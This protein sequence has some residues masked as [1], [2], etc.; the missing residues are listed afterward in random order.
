MKL[1]CLF[2]L[3]CPYLHASTAIESIAG[4]RTLFLGDSI[5]QAGT[6]V[7]FTSYYLQRLHPEKDFDIYP[8]GLGSETVSELS[9]EG[10]AGGRFPRPSLFERLDRALAKV[11]PEIIFACYGINCGIYK[12]LDE[13]RFKAFKSGVKRLISKSK[14]AGVEKIYIVTPPIYDAATKVGQF[15]YDSVMTSYAAWEMTIKEEGVQ[16]IDL[17][18]AMRKARDIRKEVFSGDRVH[19]GKEGH[20]FMANSILKGLGVEISGEDV[21]VILK[22]PFFK[23][24][25]QL[26]S[27]RGKQ[28]MK[29]V[30]YTREKVVKPQ[31][32]GETEKTVSK[33]QDEINKLRRAR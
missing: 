4:K 13:E 18:S 22:D 23:K 20:L 28:W 30:G 1:L 14:K 2:V 19:P 21:E 15:N 7:S 31:P 3:L 27:F 5:T 33:M 25:D 11:K 32:L 16:V 8:L 9:E 10:H 26:R 29:H 6:Y 17:H 24:V 12:P